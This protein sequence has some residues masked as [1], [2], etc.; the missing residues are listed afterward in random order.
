MFA[1]WL[2]RAEAKFVIVSMLFFF[3]FKL[4]TKIPIGLVT[5]T[6]SINARTL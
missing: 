6:I 5:D 4:M 3:F 1:D 2:S